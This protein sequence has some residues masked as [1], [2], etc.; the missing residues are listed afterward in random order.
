MAPLIAVGTIPEA[1]SEMTS[2]TYVYIFYT[3]LEGKCVWTIE[4]VRSSSSARCES[5]AATG[6]ISLIS[7]SS[8][9]LC[10][11]HSRRA[12]ESG[13][14]GDLVFVLQFQAFW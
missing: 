2:L 10:R 14:S 9:V 1:L 5:A 11:N 7:H 6:I 12:G 4:L 3:K 13:E 8:F